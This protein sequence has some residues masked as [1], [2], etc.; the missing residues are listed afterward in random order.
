MYVEMHHSNKNIK[1]IYYTLYERIKKTVY[2]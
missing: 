1:H 2:I